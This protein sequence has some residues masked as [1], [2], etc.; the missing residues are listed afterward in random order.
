MQASYL[1]Y[2]IRKGK[3]RKVENER[4]NSL[5][6]FNRSLRFP[7]FWLF[8]LEIMKIIVKAKIIKIEQRYKIIEVTVY[9][10][11]SNNGSIRIT[12]EIP[13]N[14]FVFD[15]SLQRCWYLS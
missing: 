11:F 15:S 5:L 12:L 9:P 13:L 6:S 2:N 7:L 1:K 3:V 10:I 14:K 8:L 4:R